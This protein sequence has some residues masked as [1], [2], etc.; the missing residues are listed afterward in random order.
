MIAYGIADGRVVARRRDGV[1]AVGDVIS[2]G[3]FEQPSLHA[4]MAQG[5]DACGTTTAAV[6]GSSTDGARARTSSDRLT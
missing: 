2:D 4:F 3:V 6:L 5:P 1:I